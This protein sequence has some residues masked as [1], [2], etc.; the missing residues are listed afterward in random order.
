MVRLLL[1]LV[2][3][4]FVRAVGAETAPAVENVPVVLWQA[5]LARET[6]LQSKIFLEARDQPLPEFL[7]AVQESS[8]VTLQV[9]APSPLT[10]KRVTVRTEAMPLHELMSA[11]AHLYGANWQRAGQSYQMKPAALSDFD[12]ELLRI[13][14]SAARNAPE[15]SVS[16]AQRRE[17]A[18]QILESVGQEKFA[19]G[20]TVSLS[21]L[22]EK[23]RDQIRHSIQARAASTLLE[24]QAAAL[25]FLIDNY[26]LYAIVPRSTT[27]RNTPSRNAPLRKT[28]PQIALSAQDG[29]GKWVAN[30]AIIPLEMLQ[31]G[32]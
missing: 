1:V 25:P 8:G 24:P 30:V 3:C 14:D 11:L 29:N 18:T 16:S 28:P 13:G 9:L 5:Q 32:T 17:L 22:P 15:Q 23:L 21:Q 31:P 26:R 20:S 6:T 19:D 4:S 2:S 10:S 27:E 7:Q 12:R